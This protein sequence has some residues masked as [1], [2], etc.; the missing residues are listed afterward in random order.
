MESTLH[1]LV[2]ILL[3]AV[4]TFILVLCLHFYLKRMF[5]I[6]LEEVLRRRRAATEGAREAAEAALN[7]AAEKAAAYEAALDDARSEVYKEQEE[8]RKGWLTAQATRVEE[9]KET[10]HTLIAQAKDGIAAEMVAARRD[11]S[12]ASSGLASQIAQRVLAGR[13]N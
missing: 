11:L 8:T 12:A 7:R 4:P 3:R 9:A 1:A 2:G 6:P 5:F 10:A 13:V